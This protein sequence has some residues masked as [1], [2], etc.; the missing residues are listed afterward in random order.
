MDLKP[1]KIEV[2][3]LFFDHAIALSLPESLTKRQEDLVNSGALRIKSKNNLSP[4]PKILTSAGGARD[5]V[6]SK[7]PVKT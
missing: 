3:N 2:F 5:K 6:F 7:G 1:L 4:K